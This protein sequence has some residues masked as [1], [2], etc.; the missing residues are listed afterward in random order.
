MTI[1]KIN[2]ENEYISIVK[3]RYILLKL[4]GGIDNIKNY[5]IFEKIINMNKIK[6]DT[7]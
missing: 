1:S 6:Y 2:D 5:V 7:V 3:I 4:Y